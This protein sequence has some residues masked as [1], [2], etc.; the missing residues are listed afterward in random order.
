MTNALHE[1]GFDANYFLESV[2]SVKD[3]ERIFS[4]NME[5]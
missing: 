3:G 1:E 2:R 4:T 5:D